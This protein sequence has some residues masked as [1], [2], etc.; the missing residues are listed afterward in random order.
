MFKAS[1]YFQ[2]I[3]TN[4]N[5]PFKQSKLLKHRK[6]LAVLVKRKIALELSYYH[7][8]I[9]LSTYIAQHGQDKP[10]PYPTTIPIPS[11]HK[12]KKEQK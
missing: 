6:Q 11:E 4:D 7:L 10:T 8:L 3:N 5:I 12:E 2:Q 9:E 1:L